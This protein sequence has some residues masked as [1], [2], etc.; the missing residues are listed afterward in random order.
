MNYSEIRDE[1]KEGNV[2]VFSL[3]TPLGSLI[4]LFTSSNY[5]H[6]PYQGFGNRDRAVGE[7]KYILCF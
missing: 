4:K 5:T 7:Q 3:N 2:I 1:I 6:V